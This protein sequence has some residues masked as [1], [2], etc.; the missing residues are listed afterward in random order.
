[1]YQLPELEAYSTASALRSPLKSLGTTAAPFTACSV[2]VTV[3]AA[4]VASPSLTVS[5]NVSGWLPGQSIRGA[6]NVGFTAAGFDSA[7][8]GPPVCVHANVNGEGPPSAS[9]D[10]EPSRVTVVRS[11]TDCAAP[12]SAV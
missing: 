8:A 4:E 10:A 9:D 1:M 3:D 2:M 11:S 7:T 12:A 5:E 6:P